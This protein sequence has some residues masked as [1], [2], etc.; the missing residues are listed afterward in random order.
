MGKKPFFHHFLLFPPFFR[1]REERERQRQRQ[2]ASQCKHLFCERNGKKKKEKGRFSSFS[3]F[4]S[5]LSPRPRAA[6]ERTADCITRK[7]RLRK[8][9]REK[10]RKEGKRR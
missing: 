8:R 5:Q 3:L 4:S 7:R 1:C 9:E 6:K 2:R 10:E